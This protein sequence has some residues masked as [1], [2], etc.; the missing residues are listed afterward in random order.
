MIISHTGKFIKI[1][2]SDEKLDKHIFK[3][4][5][6][7]EVFN[8]MNGDERIDKCDKNNYFVKLGVGSGII[9]KFNEV[10]DGVLAKYDKAVIDKNNADVVLGLRAEIAK[11]DKEIADLKTAKK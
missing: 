5:I 9:D 1:D 2:M 7:D 8:L 10:Y 11:K 6:L 4:N 3:S